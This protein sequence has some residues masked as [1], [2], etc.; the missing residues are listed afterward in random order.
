MVLFADEEM[1]AWSFWSAS[2]HVKGPHGKGTHP[3]S[4]GLGAAR[5]RTPRK[6]VLKGVKMRFI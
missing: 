1:R 5:A 4:W 6:M 2:G 3:S